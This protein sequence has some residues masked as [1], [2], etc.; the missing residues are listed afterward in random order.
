MSTLRLLRN[1]WIPW[2]TTIV[3]ACFSDAVAQASYRVT[4]LGTLKNDNLGCA[5]AVNNH[6][7]TLIPKRDRTHAYEHE[8]VRRDKRHA[9]RV[10]FRYE[11]FLAS[12]EPILLWIGH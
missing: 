3:P 2:G 1:F 7:W 9:T 8:P 11:E 12:R 4:D 5:M 6:G 10:L